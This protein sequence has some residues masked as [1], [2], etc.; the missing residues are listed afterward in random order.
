M[1]S[2]NRS[3][4][5][6]VGLLQ[7]YATVLLAQGRPALAVRGPIG[8]RGG[9]AA[10]NQDG[11]GAGVRLPGLV[12][13]VAGRP[14]GDYW[15]L[16]LDIYEELDDVGGQSG[17][18]LN[19]GAGL[20]Y[21]GRWDEALASYERAR[22][23]RLKVGDPVMAALA[24]DN[25]A[26]IECERGRLGEA[27]ELLRDSMRLWRASGNRYMLGNCLEFLARVTSRTGRTQEA[28][29]LLTEAQDAFTAVGAREDL[30]RAEA[31]VAECRVLMGEA[32]AALDLATEALNRGSASGD[33]GMTVS[34]LS[35]IRGYALAQ[36]GGSRRRRRSCNEGWTPLGLGGTSMKL[37]YR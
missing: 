13:S 6:K 8:P 36:R 14:A 10:G 22:D 7:F 17:I 30:L 5:S 32:D 2:G 23:G 28:L 20:F 25:I 16:A 12:E 11:A 34:L 35:R 27:E 24:A 3:W 26:E 15:G 37:R 18:H 4:R 21:E 9:A 31:R 33:A 1:G 19:L 29:E